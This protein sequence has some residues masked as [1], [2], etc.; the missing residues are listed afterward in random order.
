MESS[1][2]PPTPVSW[3]SSSPSFTED[4]LAHQQILLGSSSL[5]WDQTGASEPQFNPPDC[6]LHPSLRSF[7]GRR[8]LFC[9]VSPPVHPL[10][11]SEREETCVVGGAMLQLRYGKADKYL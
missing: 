7:L 9:S 6:R 3:W 4:F 1:S 10:T 8:A 2:P 5:L 11:Y